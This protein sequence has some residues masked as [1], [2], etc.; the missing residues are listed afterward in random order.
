MNVRAVNLFLLLTVSLLKYSI[1]ETMEEKK[2]ALKYFMVLFDGHTKFFYN[3]LE[4]I[5]DEDANNRLGTKAN[6]MAWIAGSLVYERYELAR[7]LGSSVNY[8]PN[9]LFVNHKGIQDNAV[10]PTLAEY[11]RDW[12]KLTPVL[13]T[14]I[15]DLSEDQL[16]GPDPFDMPG[17]DYTLFEAFTFCLERETYCIGQLGLYRRLLGYPAMKWD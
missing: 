12:E 15:F 13:K 5:S 7:L 17:G 1:M 4:G 9:D 14:A 8:T 11:R 6:H 3:S 10:Y 16:N 2:T